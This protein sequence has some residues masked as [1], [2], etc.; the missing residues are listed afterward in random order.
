MSMMAFM[1]FIM[2]FL[3]WQLLKEL[4][5]CKQIYQYLK[6]DTLLTIFYSYSLS[7]LLSY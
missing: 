5:L 3:P 1:A 2:A 4:C 7:I 6:A